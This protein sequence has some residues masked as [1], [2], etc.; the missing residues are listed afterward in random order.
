MLT[1]AGQAFLGLPRFYLSM[2][3]TSFVIVLNFIFHP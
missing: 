2:A 3:L 1:P